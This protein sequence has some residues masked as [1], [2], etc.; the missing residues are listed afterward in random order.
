MMLATGAV[1]AALHDRG[2]GLVYDDVLDVTW[3]A[4]ANYARTSGYDLDGLMTWSEATAWAEQLSYEYVVNGRNVANYEDWRLPSVRDGG[5]A[6]YLNAYS[7]T[8][9]GYNVRTVGEGG[10]VYSEMAYM[11]YVNLEFKAYYS[12]A[13][14]LQ[15]NHGIYENGTSGGERDGLGPNGVILNLQSDGYWSGTVYEPYKDTGAW[16]FYTGT[17]FN[18]S[19]YQYG[20]LQSSPFYAW[21]LRDGDVAAVPESTP[22]SMFLVGTIVVSI[23]VRKRLSSNN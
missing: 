3:L 7:G 18:F 11:Y 21:A 12:V 8:D 5:I 20:K 1:E 22:V 4:D 23:L 13:G 19:G 6:N 10:I 16:G 14:L 9:Y 2:G 15:S 17:G